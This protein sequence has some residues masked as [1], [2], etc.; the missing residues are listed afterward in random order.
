MTRINNSISDP[1]DPR[2]AFAVLR[3]AEDDAI[4]L[5]F[6]TTS[7]HLEGGQG[8]IERLIF[9]FCFHNSNAESAAS[10]RPACTSVSELLDTVI[11]LSFTQFLNTDLVNA[12]K[13]W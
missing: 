6:H 13:S 7:T 12:P 3:S 4:C 10:A 8:S 1:P 5:F 11:I 2:S 9:P